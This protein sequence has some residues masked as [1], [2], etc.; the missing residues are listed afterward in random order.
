MYGTKKKISKKIKGDMHG[1]ERLCE[2]DQSTRCCQSIIISDI[3]IPSEKSQQVP[4]PGFEPRT[5]HHK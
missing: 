5:K 1:G 4:Q 2:F 3:F